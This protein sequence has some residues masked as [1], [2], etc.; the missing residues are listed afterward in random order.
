MFVE[1]FGKKIQNQPDMTM[2]RTKI[3]S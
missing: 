2:F 1:I 3:I